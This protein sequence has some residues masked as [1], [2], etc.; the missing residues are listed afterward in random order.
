MSKGSISKDFLDL[1]ESITRKTLD[2]DNMKEKSNREQISALFK[3]L[4]TDIIGKKG[5]TR[6]RFFDF[7]FAEYDYDITI[8][9]DMKNNFTTEATLPNVDKYMRVGSKAPSTPSEYVA[10][11]NVYLGK[12][13]TMKAIEAKALIRTEDTRG[14]QITNK[15]F[16][17]L[18]SLASFYLQNVDELQ[19]ELSAD[20][21]EFLVALAFND[22]NYFKSKLTKKGNGMVAGEPS[23][24][25]YKG[26]EMYL[27][28]DVLIFLDKMYSSET[29]PDGD[30]AG[31]IA[32]MQS[33]MIKLDTGKMNANN[34]KSILTSSAGTKVVDKFIAK[35]V[36]KKT[37]EVIKKSS[38]KE[39]SITKYT[40]KQQIYQEYD[41]SESLYAG[42]GSVYF[43]RS[44]TVAQPKTDITIPL[45]QFFGNTIKWVGDFKTSIKK[46]NYRGLEGGNLNQKFSSILKDPKLV[47]SL[48]KVITHLLG[49]GFTL[50][51][52]EVIKCIPA[53]V[54]SNLTIPFS[55][56]FKEM[57]TKEAPVAASESKQMFLMYKLLMGEI[58][59]YGLNQK[60][61]TKHL[62]I[63][64]NSFLIVQ[65]KDGVPKDIAS[66]FANSVFIPPTLNAVTD[67]TEGLLNSAD[68]A[69]IKQKLKSMLD[70]YGLAIRIGAGNGLQLIAKNK[71]DSTTVAKLA[72][73]V[74][75]TFIAANRNLTA[76]VSGG[77]SRTLTPKMLN[78]TELS[79]LAKPGGA[80]LGILV[81]KVKLKKILNVKYY[82]AYY[83][84]KPNV[85]LVNQLTTFLKEP[86]PS[87]AFIKGVNEILCGGIEATYSLTTIKDDALV[88]NVT[89]KNNFLFFKKP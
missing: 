79:E 12:H 11:A 31:Y 77:V 45:Y 38:T 47:E 15:T 53:A 88:A 49:T 74:N 13:P 50:K 14:R 6:N 30:N 29:D 61:I 54:K 69:P 84:S 39:E 33:R 24:Y 80:T 37:K 3:E 52:T 17:L 82:G 48:D 2:K 73:T 87:L 23:K 10:S 1:Q 16:G 4:T 62:D 20:D 81:R 51:N 25:T 22:Q 21:N 41:P 70:D 55:T 56:L 28:G 59:S 43:K 27:P 58:S 26:I 65:S 83:T 35:V 75:Y 32:E 46:Q 9:K 68:F 67:I 78:L 8:N 72:K 18:M 86:F 36:D 76:W 44:G 57:L 19:N 66:I 64:A 60:N 63:E 85:D 89:H 42:Q 40:K 34:L 7:F 5:E 71:V